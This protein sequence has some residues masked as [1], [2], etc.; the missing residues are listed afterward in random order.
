MV[1]ILRERALGHPSVCRRSAF[2][3]S[4][5]IADAT[6]NVLPEEQDGEAGRREDGKKR[7]H[8]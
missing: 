5:C 2:E 6:G 3:K 4:H 8:V 7:R 1:G